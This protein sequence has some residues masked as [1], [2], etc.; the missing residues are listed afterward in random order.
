MLG[1][2]LWPKRLS[3]ET[4]MIIFFFFASRRWIR[5]SKQGVDQIGLGDVF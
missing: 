2:E 4:I 1:L 5:H 3:R